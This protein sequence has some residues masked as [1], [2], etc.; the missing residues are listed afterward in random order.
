M[1]GIRRVCELPASLLL[2]TDAGI[3]RLIIICRHLRLCL[4][5]FFHDASHFSPSLAYPLFDWLLILRLRQKEGT[6]REAGSA[7]D[8]RVSGHLTRTRIRSPRESEELLECASGLRLL[9]VS[10]ESGDL[11]F[12]PNVFDGQTTSRQSILEKKCS[13][14]LLLLL[15]G[16]WSL[17][18]NSCCVFPDDGSSCATDSPF[19]LNH[20]QTRDWAHQGL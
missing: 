13:P 11:S 18:A 1:P 4:P 9:R 12:L 5:P 20:P 19:P 8:E 10:R 7:I 2:F 14:L 3:A 16:S 15:T 17:V 6:R